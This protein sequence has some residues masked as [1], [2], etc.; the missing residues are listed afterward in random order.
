MSEE[1]SP[2]ENSDDEY[3]DAEDEVAVPT[4]RDEEPVISPAI[5]IITMEGDPPEIEEDKDFRDNADL[6][7]N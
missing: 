3:F 5:S 4:S 7:G 6:Q 1:P 2:L